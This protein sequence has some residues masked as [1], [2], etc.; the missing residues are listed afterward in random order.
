MKIKPFMTETG[1]KVSVHPRFRTS[2]SLIPER[3]LLT[4][5][6]PAPDGRWAELLLTD[7]ECIKLA[8]MLTKAIT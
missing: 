8:T 5:R 2:G 6:M 1:C 7:K 4:L 3:A